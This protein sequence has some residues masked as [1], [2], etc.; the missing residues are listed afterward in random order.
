MEKLAQSKNLLL[1]LSVLQ[2]IFF[3][4]YSLL[5]ILPIEI[6]VNEGDVFEQTI[7]TYGIFGHIAISVI[8]FF[9]FVILVLSLLVYSLKVKHLKTFNL[10]LSLLEFFMLFLNI[11][12]VVFI[13]FFYEITEVSGVF[14]V[15]FII[16]NALLGLGLGLLYLQNFFDAEVYVSQKKIE[17]EEKA[18]QNEAINML[19]KYNKL[20][21]EGIISEEEFE[22]KKRKYKEYI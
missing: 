18:K 13:F 5:A 6:E 8:G 12:G 4:L 7:Y 21:K 10:T 2:I 14:V 20:Y 11:A 1:I 17:K 9:Y 16:L 22:E 3:L 19:E 15:I